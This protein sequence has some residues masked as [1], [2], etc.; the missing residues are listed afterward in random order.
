MY[1][2]RHPMCL[3]KKNPLMG[4]KGENYLQDGQTEEA[5]VKLLY[6]GTE[7]KYLI[8]KKYTPIILSHV[9]II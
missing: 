6:V 8:S 7:W 1:S 2:I 9:I 4:K 3:D 5:I